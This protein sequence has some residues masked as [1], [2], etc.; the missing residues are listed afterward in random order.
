MEETVS[1]TKIDSSTLSKAFKTSD[2]AANGKPGYLVI[3]EHIKTEELENKTETREEE[4]V[5]NSDFTPVITCGTLII[6]KQ[7]SETK[8][9]VSS[10]ENTPSQ[11]KMRNKQKQENL[12]ISQDKQEINLSTDKDAGKT[13]EKQNIRKSYH[14]LQEL[15]DS[16]MANVSA[17]VRD[18][19]KSLSPF[20]NADKNPE[21]QKET[22]PDEDVKIG[23][24]DNESILDPGAITNLFPDFSVSVLKFQDAIESFSQA[25]FTDVL[26]DSYESSS[27]TK[28]PKSAALEEKKDINEDHLGATKHNKFHELK[29]TCE[30]KYVATNREHVE[31]IEEPIVEQFVSQLHEDH[32][33]IESILNSIDDSHESNDEHDVCIDDAA[34]RERCESRLEGALLMEKEK[35]LSPKSDDNEYLTDKSKLLPKPS[36]QSLNNFEGIEEAFTCQDAMLLSMADESTSNEEPLTSDITSPNMEALVSPQLE[37]KIDHMA[38]KIIEDSKSELYNNNQ[39]QEVEMDMNDDSKCQQ[40]IPEICISEDIREDEPAEE[41]AKEEKSEPT[42]ISIPII[43][44]HSMPEN[45][46]T[47]ISIHELSDSEV[48]EESTAQKSPVISEECNMKNSTRKISEPVQNSI[49]IEEVT[50][51]NSNEKEENVS[52]AQDVHIAF[53]RHVEDMNEEAEMFV[54]ITRE[55]ELGNV[56]KSKQDYNSAQVSIEETLTYDQEVKDVCE[57]ET[58]QIPTSE[59][60]LNQVNNAKECESQALLNLDNLSAENLD[61]NELRSQTNIEAVNM[62]A[63]NTSENSLQHAETIQGEAKYTFTPI[64]LPDENDEKEKKTVNSCSTQ[65]SQQVETSEP[66]MGWMKAFAMVVTG[67]VLITYLWIPSDNGGSQCQAVHDEHGNKISACSTDGYIGLSHLNYEEL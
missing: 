33:V 37:H 55:V 38:N 47:Q 3:E 57:Y 18:K 59:S 25:V 66:V 42:W 61:I 19:S 43:R 17:E 6:R 24:N 26:E 28:S 22:L 1:E 31:V 34:I 30:P 5:D 60:Q 27:Y 58:D 39:T 7:G 48:V 50:S 12:N 51:S 65:T 62:K 10:D 49:Q 13:D 54:P 52:A 40:S 32:E 9:K 29:E 2:N 41:V 16:K 46:G 53:S 44:G 63:M 15:F 14:L 23:T 64:Q 35:E 8:R 11:V 21:K 4:K 56:S 45:V 36:A 20:P 67:A